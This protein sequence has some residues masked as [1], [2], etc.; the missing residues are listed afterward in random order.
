MRKTITVLTLLGLLTS[1]T[2][3]G[4]WAQLSTGI[5]NSSFISF[6][7]NG[8]TF[9]LSYGRGA[10]GGTTK[11]T[12]E[13]TNWSG[14][15]S[16]GYANYSFAVKNTN[17]MIAGTS[18]G[19]RYYTI[20]G[21]WWNSDITWETRS[22][23]TDGTDFYAGTSAG[24]YKS[25]NNGQNWSSLGLSATNVKCLLKVGT[26]MFAGSS[27]GLYISS[28]N[29]SSWNLDPHLYSINCL[30]YGN[31]LLWI[32]TNTGLWWS[33]DLCT[34]WHSVTVTGSYIS[35]ALNASNIYVSSSTGGVK[36]LTLVSPGFYQMASRNFGFPTPLPVVNCMIATN[37]YLLAGTDSS[38]WRSPLSYVTEIKPQVT[39]A[40][41]VL[42]QNYPNPFNPFTVIKYLLPKQG[43][44]LL[45]I[46]D[47]TGREIETLVNEK[48][49]PGTYE[50]SWDASQYSSG[51][52][53]FRIEA[54]NFTDTKRM[55]LI[56]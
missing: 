4:Q 9:Y 41:F 37:N 34:S 49:S 29:G 33:D 44:I 10:S 47:I 19:I 51:V 1:S 8:S 38:V 17:A 48:Q 6:H 28:N 40:K 20:G 53:F 39:P 56:K 7:Q 54:E 22:V 45:K 15:G 32:G 2:V 13:G 27:A 46:Y 14:A 3:F 21:Y 23:L 30:A 43:I 26:Y 36:H 11:T 24:V 18:N 5:I 52:Y 12:N 35:I 16:S 25:T 42:K 55:L 31:N 50:V